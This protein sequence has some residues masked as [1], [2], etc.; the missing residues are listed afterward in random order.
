MSHIILTDIGN[1][2]EQ[3]VRH[4]HQFPNDTSIFLDSKISTEQLQLCQ[5]KASELKGCM[6]P[7]RM[8]GK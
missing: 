7:T 2:V 8:Q 3:D 4:F 6:F 1:I 5:P